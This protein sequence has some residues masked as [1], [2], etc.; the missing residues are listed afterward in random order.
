MRV[1]LKRLAWA[2]VLCVGLPAAAQTQLQKGL[3]ELRSFQWNGSN[4]SN[5][6]L[7]IAAGFNGELATLETQRVFGGIDASGEPAAMM[8][9]A[10]GTGQAS[11]GAL[12]ASAAIEVWNPLMPE[13]VVSSSLFVQSSAWL[14]EDLRVGNAAVTSIRFGLRIDGSLAA[15]RPADFDGDV[16][17]TAGVALFQGEGA[18]FVN[19]RTLYARSG[20]SPAGVSFDDLAYTNPINVVNGVAVLNVQFVAQADVTMSAAAAGGFTAQSLFNHTASIVEV[21]GYD[22]A[23]L[24][25]ALPDVRTAAGFVYQPAAMPVPEPGPLALL[26]AG[27]GVLGLVCRRQ[28]AAV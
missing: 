20:N 16:W 18:N 1:L 10:Q 28:A 21:Y 24:Q 4:G 26:V 25:V 6:S 8:V 14:W 15:S 3:V 9:V 22:S 5:A 7:A 2:A 27:L 13:G 11:A 17:P 23:G 12:K 19:A